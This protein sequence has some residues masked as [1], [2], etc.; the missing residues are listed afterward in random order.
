MGT[1]NGISG[2]NVLR[3]KLRTLLQTN[4]RDKCPDEM[5]RCGGPSMASALGGG[6]LANS[7]PHWVGA[8]S[9]HFLIA[10]SRYVSA[11]ASE[12]I[13][14]RWIPVVVRSSSL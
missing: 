6:C 3:L 14:I 9:C 11:N 5:S 7:F 12:E 10:A 2:T 1:A 8:G 13:S 4:S